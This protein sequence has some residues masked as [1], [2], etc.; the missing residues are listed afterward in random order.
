VC[1][2]HKLGELKRL[3]GLLV[4]EASVVWVV[5]LADEPESSLRFLDQAKEL[6]GEERVEL[7]VVAAQIHLEVNVRVM[8]E[9]IAEAVPSV[10]IEA[11]IRSNN[12]GPPT[13]VGCG[14]S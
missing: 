11:V 5:R 13:S 3:E 2:Q 8:V 6:L 14:R 1:A 12:A 4:T 10:L 7:A 9:M